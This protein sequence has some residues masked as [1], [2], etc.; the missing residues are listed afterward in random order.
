LDKSVISFDFDG[1]LA[2]SIELQDFAK[3]LAEKGVSVCI[4][5]RRSN[6]PVNNAEYHEQF[7]HQEVERL[8]SAL[9]INT[10][11]YTNGHYKNIFFEGKFG[12]I[13]IDDDDTEIRYIVYD[14]LNAKNDVMCF[15]VMEIKKF[16]EYI[17]NEFGINI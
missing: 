9:K 7:P 1:T 14:K 5:T 17:I 13:H 6:D 8:A 12:Y 4:T 3:L 10:I 16:K 15:N 2:T 11:N